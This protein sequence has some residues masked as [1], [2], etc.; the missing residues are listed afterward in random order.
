MRKDL[1]PLHR[2]NQCSEVEGG[3]R[4]GWGLCLTLGIIVCIRYI[5]LVQYRPAHSTTR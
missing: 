3:G 2:T 5:Q 4:V 1:V